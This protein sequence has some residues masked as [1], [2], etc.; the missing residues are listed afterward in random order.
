M[1]ENLPTLETLDTSPFKK[2]VLSFGAVPTD[3]KES[4]TYYELLSWLCN[5]IEKE[6]IPAINQHTEEFDKL[7]NAYNQLKDYV[8]NYFK[9]LDVQ[10]E[11]NNK[12]DEMAE[13]GELAE[14]IAQFLN[15]G[16][17]FGFDTIADMAEA[18]YLIDGSICKVLGKTN[19]TSGDGSFYRIRQRLNSDEPDGLNIVVLPNTSNLVA[20]IIP[21]YNYDQLN[22][23]NQNHMMVFDTLEEAEEANIPVGR[24]FRTNGKET[25]NDGEGA[26]YKKGE[27]SNTLVDFIQENYYDEI[28]FETSYYGPA[29]TTYYLTY[30]PKLDKNDDLIE[31]YQGS[32]AEHQNKPSKYAKANFT[33]VTFNFSCTYLENNQ[34]YLPPMIVNG[35]I[36][37]N[38]PTTLPDTYK[39]LAMFPDRTW[40][41]YPAN[42]SMETIKT[43]G[44]TQATLCFGQSV[45]NGT[46]NFVETNVRNNLQLLGVKSNGDIILLTS[47]YGNHNSGLT[48]TEGCNI[49]IEKGCSNVFQL[50]GG[51]STSTTVKGTRIN[52]FKDDSNTTERSI[53]YTLNAKKPTLNKT[54]GKIYNQ[55]GNATE[56]IRK[57]T[58][59]NIE[60]YPY[61]LAN[62][63]FN[64]LDTTKYGVYYADGSV[65]NLP[66]NR[67]GYIINIPR[68]TA[69][70]PYSNGDCY[71]ELHATF[72]GQKYYRV[73]FNGTFTN[74][75]RVDGVTDI[76]S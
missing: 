55:I 76:G 22:D 25:I 67:A 29:H 32:T 20:E 69:S 53:Q 64:N 15:L 70:G 12:L 73:K 71:Q 19:A 30:I 16:A 4:M 5:Y 35:E 40:V 38:T 2:L 14:A 33:T 24:T 63:D 7:I 75:M 10:E 46:L 34:W 23:E 11:I 58:T 27:N 3:F 52:A 36:V 61:L 42:T 18:T 1:S 49:L 9:N 44:A 74:W 43:A 54:I 37:T 56:N 45:I 72:S 31:L 39:Y 57:S 65:T 13:S 26:V 28:Y 66:Q 17:V 68:V 8:E 41:I 48:L 47:D 60:V 59:S 51:G 21:D 62:M 50:D 6:I